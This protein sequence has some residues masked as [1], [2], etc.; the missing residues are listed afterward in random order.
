MESEHQHMAA[1]R[2]ILHDRAKRLARDLR[3]EAVDDFWR[4]ADVVWTASL[5][6]AHRSAYRL[7]QRLSRHAR[8]RTHSGEVVE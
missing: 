2:D 5:D 6:A 3:R 4:G 7:A 1:D 8:Q